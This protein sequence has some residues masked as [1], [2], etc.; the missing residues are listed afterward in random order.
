MVRGAMNGPDHRFGHFHPGLKPRAIV[1]RP[2]RTVKPDRSHDHRPVI[3][4]L[5]ARNDEQGPQT[6]ICRA[7][8]LFQRGCSVAVVV[9]AHLLAMETRK[10]ADGRLQNKFRLVKRLYTEGYGKQ[11]IVDL[12]RFIDWIMDLPEAHERLFWEEMARYEEGKKMPYVTSV[13]RIGIEKGLRQGS[14]NLLVRLIARRF[15][16]DPNRVSSMLEG[17]KAEE[18]EDLGE[19]FVDAED[20][21]QIRAW[22]EE[23][24]SG[25]H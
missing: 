9:E 2:Y 16:A 6:A 17:L 19:R 3:Y 1:R 12:F 4:G 22:A 10:D 11:E 25:V 21:D 7:S 14:M 15:Q 24:R 5:A 13:E 20:L 18:I 8:V 23:K